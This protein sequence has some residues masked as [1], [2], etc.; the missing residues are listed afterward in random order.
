MLSPIPFDAA[1][2]GRRRST[3]MPKQTHKCADCGAANAPI[4][5]D[6]KTI[7]T[8]GGRWLCCYCA[9]L[10]VNDPENMKYTQADMDLQDHLENGGKLS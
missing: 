3:A 10:R 6:P 8:Y 5:I 7:S 1:D 4:P 2:L 9:M